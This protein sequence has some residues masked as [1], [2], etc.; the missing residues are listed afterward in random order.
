MINNAAKL[1][2]K[3]YN[4]NKIEKIF[5]EMIEKFGQVVAQD[6]KKC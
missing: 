2:N 1:Q 4:A 5:F 3:I 6:E